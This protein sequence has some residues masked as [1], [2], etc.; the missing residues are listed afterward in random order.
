[1]GEIEITTAMV[2]AGVK[3]FYSQY[4]QPPYSYGDL[5][6]LVSAI[7]VAALQVSHSGGPEHEAHK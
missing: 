4:D 7:V 1:M 5:R 2:E 3:A 6:E